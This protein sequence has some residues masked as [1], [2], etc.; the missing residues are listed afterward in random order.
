MN[1]CLY[2]TL[3]KRPPKQIAIKQIAMYTGHTGRHR[4]AMPGYEIVVHNRSLLVGE[5]LF[6]NCAADISCAAGDKY[7]A[8]AGHLIM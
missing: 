4:F 5:Q 1:H 8:A 7:G 3:G 6:H 2:A